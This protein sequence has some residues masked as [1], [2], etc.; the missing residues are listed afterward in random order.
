MSTARRKQNRAR[1]GLL[2]MLIAAPLFVTGCGSTRD[3]AT[4][5][6]SSDRIVAMQREKDGLDKAV[7]VVET[8]IRIYRILCSSGVLSFC[9]WS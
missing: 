2:V 6:T 8:G 3:A 1:R 5:P 9:H 4:A 7:K